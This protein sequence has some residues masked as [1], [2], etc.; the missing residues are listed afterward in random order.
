MTAWTT[1]SAVHPTLDAKQSPKR[2]QKKDNQQK[3]DQ[4]EDVKKNLKKKPP[5][6]GINSHI[7]EYA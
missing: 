6:S 2:Q 4:S 7:D 3:H 5:D 1:T